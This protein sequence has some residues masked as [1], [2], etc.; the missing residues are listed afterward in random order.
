M[1]ARS[2]ELQKSLHVCFVSF[3][4]LSHVMFISGTAQYSGGIAG[5]V[6][7]WWFLPSRQ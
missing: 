4:G 1:T 7:F 3:I 5:K 6:L 2:D